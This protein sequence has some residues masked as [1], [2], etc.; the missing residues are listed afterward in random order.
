M[1]YNN[2][3]S[4]RKSRILQAAV[5]ATLAAAP[6]VYGQQGADGQGVAAGPFTLYPS[7]GVRYLHDNNIFYQ[8][9]GGETSDNILVIS[10]QL[11]FRSEPGGQLYR[12]LYRADIGRYQDSSPD[13]YEDQQ[14]LGELEV[15][16]GRRGRLDVQ[17]EYLDA[18]DPRG[19]GRTE[20]ARGLP[21]E[22]DKWHS[23]RVDATVT[24]GTEAA[25][26]RL[27][28]TG[29]LYRKR[30]DN[31]RAFTTVRDRDAD[32][33][34]A[35][36]FYKLRERTDLLFQVDQ[37]EHDYKSTDLDSTERRYLAGVTWQATG[38][39]QGTVK[40]GRLEKDFDSATRTDFDGTSW[41]AAI[42]WAPR[43]YSVVDLATS[44]RTDETNGTGDFILTKDLSLVWRH[45][46]KSYITTR[47]SA[48]VANDRYDPSGR[49]DDRSNFGVEV[50]YQ[51]RRWLAIGAA[52]NRLKRDSNVDVFDYNKNVYGLTIRG[53]L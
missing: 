26:G 8:P 40:V 47:V 19:T 45:E 3:P 23:S 46:W 32:T 25:R 37:R 27:E 17:A 53:A 21:P 43:T 15:G 10:P 48:L 38:K 50:S 22:P 34:G 7:L 16:L 14:L 42:Q 31:N 11:D 41:T 20:G 49:E 5:V 1:G 36:F 39:T 28:L 6:G 9:A 12:I 4:V 33:L 24:I 44:R 35:T 51:F 18:H 30:Y 29:G 2:R 52:Y 13:D